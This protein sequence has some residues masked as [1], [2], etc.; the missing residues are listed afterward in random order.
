MDYSF[1]D[2]IYFRPAVFLILLISTIITAISLSFKMREYK[3]FIY[4]F[5]SFYF[6]FSGFGSCFLYE[7]THPFI[8]N[9][10]VG[11]FAIAL[12]FYF[13]DIFLKPPNSYVTFK[14]DNNFKVLIL[15]LVF[16]LLT[17]PLLYPS[18]KLQH[19]FI[20]KINKLEDIIFEGYS[21]SSFEIIIGYLTFLFLIFFNDIISSFSEKKRLFFIIL[22]MYFLFTHSG[23]LARGTIIMTLLPLFFLFIK[24]S[25]LSAVKLFMLV[26]ITLLS[27]LLFASFMSIVRSGNDF[28]FES[29]LSS[30]EYNI[31]IE[32]SFPRYFEKIAEYQNSDNFF[33]FYS[34][35]ISLPIPKIFFPLK[36]TH[37]FNEEISTILNGLSPGSSGY[38]V[39]LSGIV[40]EGY[41]IAG[42]FIFVHLFVCSAIIFFIIK[43]INANKGVSYM[44]YYYFLFISFIVN[45]AGFTGFFASTLVPLLFYFTINYILNNIK[46]TSQH[47]S[48]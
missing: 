20:P 24:K 5:F 48:R 18:F 19:L 16:V 11:L 3:L 2:N 31:Y 43:I 9:Y 10:L 21:K 23:G 39:E 33:R 45:R 41:Y 40:N 22:Y 42:N 36:P 28:D 17:I 13:S 30:F 25:N 44:T 8:F 6:I 37:N 32:F 35:L 15:I 34:W 27:I 26:S 12:G 1:L 47:D 38:F 14:G 7:L 29:L 46:F 4:I